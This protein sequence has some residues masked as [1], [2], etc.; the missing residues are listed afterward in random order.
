[1]EALGAIR[2]GPAGLQ[3]R[4]STVAL[5]YR[6]FDR[7]DFGL[8]LAPGVSLPT[9]ALGAGGDFTAL[10]TGSVDP[11]LSGDVFYGGTW[12]TG[13]SA[14]T[15]VPAVPGRDGVVQGSFTIVDLRVARRQGDAVVWLGGSAAGQRQSFGEVAVTTGVAVARWD[16]WA[17]AAHLR[18]PVWGDSTYRVAGG[19]T[20]TRVIRR[21]EEDEHGPDDGHDH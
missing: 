8:R 16:D 6:P 9:G 11:I 2:T 13:L 4:D 17:L 3:L 20:V 5:A 12:L 15:R 19:V 10:S 14:S 7:P 18:V 1:M 21:E